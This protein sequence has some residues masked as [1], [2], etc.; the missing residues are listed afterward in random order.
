MGLVRPLQPWDILLI[1]CNNQLK[2]CITPLLRL[3]RKGD[4]LYSPSDVYVRSFLCPFLYF[5]KTLLHKTLE[6]SG[7]FPGHPK[8]KS[9]SLEIT[10]LT[11]FTKVFNF[12]HSTCG[13][14]YSSTIQKLYRNTHT[15]T[16]TYMGLPKWLSGKESACQC[17][18]Q[19]SAG[20]ISGS[21]RSLGEE[22][23]NP[24]QFPCLENPMNRGTWWVIY[25]WVTKSW[26]WLSN[27]AYT[28]THTHTNAHIHTYIGLPQWLSGKES[29][30]QCRRC[31][32][33]PWVFPWSFPPEERC[34]GEGNGNSLQYSCLEIPWTENPGGLQ[35][36]GLQKNQTEL[37]N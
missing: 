8:T 6:R 17:R 15:H 24:L 35:S 11:S 7:L 12:Y 19:G 27:W 20:L 34:S 2:K 1:Y 22:N 3:V 28:H 29:T 23:G 31:G 33:N 16:H 30:C 25:C 32:F 18:R 14:L 10:N 26:T 5:N 9:F 21:G 4:T 36:T 13:L 37:G